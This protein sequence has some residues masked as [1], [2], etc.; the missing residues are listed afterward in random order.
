MFK[1]IRRGIS[2]A[3]WGIFTVTTIGFNID[4]HTCPYNT[5]TYNGQNVRHQ[6]IPFDCRFRNFHLDITANSL[7]GLL[8]IFVAKQTGDQ[9]INVSIGAGLIGL[10]SDVTNIDAFIAIEEFSWHCD[11]TA[12]GAGS[13][14]L[15]AWTIQIDS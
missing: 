4:N 14:N 1:V 5:S 3:I 12:A 11:S 6:T 8:T 10:F 15:R 2:R 7:T 9:T 13:A